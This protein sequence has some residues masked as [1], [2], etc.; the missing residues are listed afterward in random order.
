M[1]GVGV[2]VGA[3]SWRVGAGKSR[4]LEGWSGWEQEAGEWE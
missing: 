4:K 3:V 2:G 1:L